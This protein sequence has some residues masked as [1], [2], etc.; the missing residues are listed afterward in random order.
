MRHEYSGKHKPHRSVFRSWRHD[1]NTKAEPAAVIV[2][3]RCVRTAEEQ[4]LQDYVTIA[5]NVEPQHP[6]LWFRHRG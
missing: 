5:A 1:I 4:V 6:H 2:S 3:R